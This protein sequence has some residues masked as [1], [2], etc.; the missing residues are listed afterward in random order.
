MK[1]TAAPSKTEK[2]GEKAYDGW[3]LPFDQRN[4]SLNLAP[5]KRLK[6]RR[7]GVVGGGG[8]GGATRV[9]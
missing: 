5:M 7:H 1:A 8:G 4:V 2:E 9:Q 6:T 3:G